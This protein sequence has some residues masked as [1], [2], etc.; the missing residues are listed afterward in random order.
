MLESQGIVVNTPYRGMRLMEVDGTR[1][2]QILVV[3][4]SLEQLA[5]QEAATAYRHD[6]TVLAELEQALAEM[7]RAVV[8]N[9]GVVHARA[10][11]AFHRSLCRV[12]GNEVLLPRWDTLARRLTIIFSLAAL[13]KE[14]DGIYQEHVELLDLLKRGNAKAIRIAVED[15][16]IGQGESIDFE[17]LTPRVR[18]RPHEVAARRQLR[19]SE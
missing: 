13:Q 3:R 8:E 9:D 5:A 17:G 7:G 10:D 14:L 15:H 6:P 1:L 18:A 11:I 19:P 12:P 2:H 16:I 4:A